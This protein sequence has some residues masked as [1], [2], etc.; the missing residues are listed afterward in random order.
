MD[1]VSDL[2]IV[3]REKDTVLAAGNIVF[4]AELERM[5]SM[6]PSMALVALDRQSDEAEAGSQMTENLRSQ[7]ARLP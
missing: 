3:D 1:E 6:H 5:A 2:W 7:E 4:P